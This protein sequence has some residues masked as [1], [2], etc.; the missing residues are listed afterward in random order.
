[1]KKF[2]LLAVAALFFGIA[3]GYYMSHVPERAEFVFTDATEGEVPL[4]VTAEEETTL[5]PEGVTR[6]VLSKGDEAIVPRWMWV[7]VANERGVMSTNSLFRPGERCGI[8]FGGKVTVLDF[9]D[10]LPRVLVAYFSPVDE[11]MGTQCPTGA[12][13]FLPVQEFATM[14]PR[15]EAA[16]RAAEKQAALLR[17]ITS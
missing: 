10:E 16:K 2:L 1:M 14:T 17:R 11:A 8:E 4:P 6:V 3:T 7:E 5:E 13:F 9:D 15:F 12:V